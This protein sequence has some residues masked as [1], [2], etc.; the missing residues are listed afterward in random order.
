[1]GVEN[2]HVKDAFHIRIR[3]GQAFALA[4]ALVGGALYDVRS[5]PVLRHEG[6]ALRVAQ[7]DASPWSGHQERPSIGADHEGHR[8]A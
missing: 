1:M 4:Q 8:V 3:R 5:G 7:I 6:A 2:K